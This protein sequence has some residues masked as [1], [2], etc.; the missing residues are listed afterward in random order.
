VQAAPR[1]VNAAVVGILLAALHQPV[2]TS[3]ITNAKDF[4]LGVVAFLL[5]FT[6]KTPPWLVVVVCALGGAGLGWMPIV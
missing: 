3:D 4:A 2:W 6:W 1:R 5:L